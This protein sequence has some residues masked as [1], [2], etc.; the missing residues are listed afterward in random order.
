M[1]LTITTML[2]SIVFILTIVPLTTLIM[3]LYKQNKTEDKSEE[4]GKL[5]NIILKVSIA[6]F[7]FL[8]G[9][10]VSCIVLFSNGNNINISIISGMTILATLLCIANWWA[11]YGIKKII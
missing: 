4:L 3:F 5:R 2:L 7:L 6:K 8:C 9:E 1:I 11:F 10:V